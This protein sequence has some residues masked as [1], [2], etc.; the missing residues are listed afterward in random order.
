[1]GKLYDR[2]YSKEY[3]QKHKEGISKRQ[4]EYNLRNKEKLSEYKSKWREDNRSRRIKEA[5]EYYK[6]NK[7]DISI[8]RSER[9]KENKN[10]CIKHY[11]GGT[12]QCAICDVDNIN[13]LVLDHINNDGHKDRRCTNSL[14][15]YLIREGFPLGFQ[16]LCA[17]HNQEK[18]ILYNQVK[19]VGKDIIYG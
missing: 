8:R 14:Y 15:Y 2:K 6:N 10:T 13:M 18:A 12:M 9:H 17:N 16:V 7:V 19:T 5:K 3:Y 11:S 4:R 1:M